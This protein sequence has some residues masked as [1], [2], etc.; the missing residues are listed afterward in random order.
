MPNCCELKK[1][2]FLICTIICPVV[3]GQKPDS[4]EVFLTEYQKVAFVTSDSTYK[5][6]RFISPDGKFYFREGFEDAYQAS[7]EL[8]YGYSD[9]IQKQGE[10]KLTYESGSDLIDTINNYFPVKQTET[11]QDYLINIYDD[12]I[13]SYILRQVGETNK[14]NIED[15]I[16]RIV[17]PYEELNYC[18]VFYVFTIRFLADSAK[19][20]I[21][22][23]KSEDF[24]GIQLT[25]IDSCLLNKKDISRVLKQMDKVK[26]IPDMDCRRP[27][28]PWILEYNDGT[29]YKCFAISNYCLRGQK[30][31]RPVASL[32]YFILGLGNKYF[33]THY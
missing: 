23:G 30:E 4:L 8:F 16:I 15:N 2:L 12:L 27:G 24:K 17:Y 18:T 31:L 20:Y 19:L 9:L 6:T 22:T 32:C 14:I 26:S 29:E 3:N 25:Q 13:Y 5:F 11:N 1:I 10:Y 33:E 21:H 7:E 28:N